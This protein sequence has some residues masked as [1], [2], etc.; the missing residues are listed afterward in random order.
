VGGGFLQVKP[1]SFSQDFAADV[2]KPIAHFMAI[3]QV[4]ISTQAFTAKATAAW[5][6][7]ASYAV[8][9]K[10]DRMINPDLE[11]FMAGRAKSQT[12]ELS[13][14]HALYI[15]HAKDVAVLIENAAKAAE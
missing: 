9:A 3:S 7:K 4:P 15:S 1:E 13:G 10:Q 8:I 2:P 14:S 11:R 12:T 5:S 6:K